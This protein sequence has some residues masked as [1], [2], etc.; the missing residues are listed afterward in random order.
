M[1]IIKEELASW[2]N[3]KEKTKIY[4]WVLKSYSYFFINGNIRKI[5]KTNISYIEPHR[6]IV[7]D[8]TFLIFD[9]SNDVYI[10][11]LAKKVR[12]LELEDHINSIK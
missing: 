10:F 11:N 5:D 3:L 4:M 9:Y 8:I 12:L 1:K 7:K 2:G 6:V